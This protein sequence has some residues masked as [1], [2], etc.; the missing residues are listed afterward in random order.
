M[1]KRVV[2]RLMTSEEK[3]CGNPTLI[4]KGCARAQNVTH[5][6]MESV[7]KGLK[8]KLMISPIDGADVFT[9]IF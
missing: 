1:I 9:Q 8:T 4:Y 3:G 2:F 5:L 6:L 7:Y